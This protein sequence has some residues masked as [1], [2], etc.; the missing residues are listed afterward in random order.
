MKHAHFI[1]GLHLVLLAVS[2]LLLTPSLAL[3]GKDNPKCE[4]NPLFTPFPSEYIYN[5]E[6]S[7]YQ[8]IPLYRYKDPVKRDDIALVS[9]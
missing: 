2:S 4:K 8:S 6:R 9:G 1:R 7:N 5:C 3:A